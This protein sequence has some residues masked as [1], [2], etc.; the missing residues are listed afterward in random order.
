M[1][2]CFDFS[3]FKLKVQ[4]LMVKVMGVFKFVFL[5]L[6]LIREFVFSEKKGW[7]YYIYLYIFKK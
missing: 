6:W 7:R 5:L 3:V 1:I 4:M 2:I